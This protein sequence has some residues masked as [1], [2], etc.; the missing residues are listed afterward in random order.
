MTN[1]FLNYDDQTGLSINTYRLPHAM[2]GDIG[3][4]V[5]DGVLGHQCVTCPL[6]GAYEAL[7]EVHNFITEYH[8][9]QEY[10]ESIRGE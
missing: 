7:E 3:D 1:L 4:L 9:E 6:D 8:K 2:A 5:T 10:L